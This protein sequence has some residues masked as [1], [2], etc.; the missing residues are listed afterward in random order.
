MPRLSRIPFRIWLLAILIIAH[1]ISAVHPYDLQ[2][3]IFE[4]IPTAAFLIFMI[5]YERL[6]PHGPLSNRSCTLLL[7]FLLLHIVGAHYLYTNVPYDRWSEWL[8]GTSISDIFGWER[9]HYD[10]LVHFLFGVLCMLPM[11]EVVQRAVPAP[12]WKQIVIAMLILAFLSH[13]Y[14]WAEW[15]LTMVVSPEAAEN[16]NGQQGDMFDAQ[17]DTFLAFIGSIISAAA[18]AVRGRDAVS[19][20]A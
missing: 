20:A 18:I 1:A 12:R 16:Y 4:H 2:D 5:A 7:I 8:F 13:V 9:N 14:E 17:K 19:R 11:V 6:S 3:F 10:R 15:G